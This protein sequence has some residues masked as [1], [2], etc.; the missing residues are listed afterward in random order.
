MK[1]QFHI[2]IV[3]ELGN[4]HI[5]LQYHKI[6]CCTHTAPIAV[7][8]LLGLGTSKQSNVLEHQT[9]QYCHSEPCSVARAH[10]ASV[11]LLVASHCAVFHFCLCVCV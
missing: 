9:E 6:G 2:C 8:N 3:A 7:L 4:L 5:L 10:S 1:G 11:S